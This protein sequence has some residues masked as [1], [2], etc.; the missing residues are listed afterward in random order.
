MSAPVRASAPTALGP[1]V[2]PPAG[3]LA[4]TTFDPSP[5]G[6]SPGHATERPVT[7]Q[8]PT[9]VVPPPVELL[10]GLALTVADPEV[11]GRAA[12]LRELHLA[13]AMAARNPEAP[14]PPARDD[15]PAPKP[16]PFGKTMM[17]GGVSAPAAGAAPEASPP[18]QSV[19]APSAWTPD[20]SVQPAP[21]SPAPEPPAAP[22][23]VAE[24]AASAPG[25]D[26]RTMVGMPAVGLAAPAPSPPIAPAMKTMMGV[27]LP[28]IAPTH[29]KPAPQ[30]APVE[31]AGT[32]LGVAAPG[33]APIRPG[34]APTQPLQAAHAP[35]PAA[36]LPPI[37]PAPAPLVVEPL[38]AAPQVG[39]KKGVPAVAVVGI[40]F[41]LVAIIG[42]TAAIL[43]LRGG[44]PLSAQPRLDETGKE[45][46][47]IR[48]E[49]CPDGT[50]VSLGASSSKIAGATAILPLP[51][52]LS[53]G[54]NDLEMKIDRPPPGRDET[55]KVHVPVAYRVKAD[56]SS[57]TASPAAITVR[58]EALAG[59]EVTVDGKPVTLDSSG[60]GSQAIDVTSEVEGP[61][62][63]Q[64][65]IDKKIAFAIKPKGAAAAENG[66]LVVRTGIAPLHI[67]APGLE[68]YTDRSTGNVAGQIKPGGTLSIDGQNVTVDPQGR[69]GVRVELPASSEKVLTIVANAPPLAP[70]TVRA[71]LV[72]VASLDAAAKTLD[73]KAPLAFDAYGA[74]PKSKLGQLVVVDGEIQEI[75]V[76]QG[77]TV[78]AVEE[79]KACSAGPKA[80][81]VRV[82]HG[83]E[84]RGARGDAV[85]AYGRIEG[86][87]A[88]NGSTI[89]DVEGSLV[90]VRP[91]AKK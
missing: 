82:V 77:H 7:S 44:A 87:A 63:E 61:S 74:D 51:A 15:A 86:T 1:A 42:S 3:D 32:L 25:S 83:E 84:V 80:C 62:D 13:E 20:G 65:S 75:R 8:R 66:E 27:A 47:E 9:P 76:T 22:S 48:C 33:I 56:L 28:G 29:D 60:R 40:V 69:F 36:P 12:Q 6:A 72:R 64:K 52:P 49:S 31:R 89:P 57:L 38:P 24:R 73:A 2:R 30:R 90:L 70:R 23:P 50:V 45:S 68:L 35:A 53:I 5:Y 88:L 55:V 18:S 19:L 37:V 10:P 79:K 11:A 39:K 85:R 78:M 91:A 59:A 46:L 54:D 16:A 67:D 4:S 41:A 71:K 17:L 26:K 81:V 14:G 58:V 21:F 34:V 43:V